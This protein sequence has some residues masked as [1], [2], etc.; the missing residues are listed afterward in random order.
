MKKVCLLILSLLFYFPIFAQQTGYN[1]SIYLPGYYDST[2]YLGNYFGD[3]MAIADT[4]AADKSTFAFSGVE[5]LKQGVYFLV[6]RDKKKAFEFMVG[7]DQ[8]FSIEKEFSAPPHEVIFKGS[9]E[10]EIFYNY[11]NYNKKSYDRVKVIRALMQ[12]QPPGSDSLQTLQA[13]LEMINEEGI[14]YKLDIIDKYPEAVT[15]MLFNV[16]REPEVPDF[17]LADGRQDSN[18][19]YLY[20]RNHYWEYVDLSDDRILRT[21]VFHRKLERYMSK[22]VTGH[23]D[24]LIRE[25]DNMIARTSENSEMRHYL[26]WY[27]TNT[28]ETSKV[29]GYD[30]IFVHMVD[31]YFTEQGYDWLHPTA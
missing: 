23:P 20:Y 12:K 8:H 9:E 13:E 2:A 5:P 29:M 11:L 7:A 6:T 1:I 18:A 17:F 21:P 25:I 3:K 28:Y 19:A 22:V 10:N 15:A 14:A 30:K 27:F 4:A 31:T 26:L 24:T 16:M